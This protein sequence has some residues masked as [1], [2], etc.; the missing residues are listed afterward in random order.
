[1][2]KDNKY[3]DEKIHTFSKKNS[4]SISCKL[5]LQTQKLRPY[6]VVTPQP[7]RLFLLAGWLR[8]V[9]LQL[10]ENVYP[11]CKLWHNNP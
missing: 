7:I 8:G 11:K 4:P 10:L 5:H 6:L 9:G 1:M 3:T 2:I